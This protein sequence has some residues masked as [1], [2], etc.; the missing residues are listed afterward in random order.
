MVNCLNKKRYPTERM[1]DKY[2]N[3]YNKDPF[4]KEEE[5]LTTYHCPYHD[6]WHVGHVEQKT[7]PPHIRVQKLLDKI[8]RD[9]NDPN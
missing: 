9:K 5:F 1:A 6:G 4:I 3:D 2:A 8:K 7:L